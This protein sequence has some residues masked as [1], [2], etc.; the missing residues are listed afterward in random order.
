MLKILFVGQTW[1]GSCARSMKEALAKHPRIDLDEM[2][3]D[4]FT[5]KVNSKLLRGLNK[6]VR[7]LYRKEFNQQV[8]EK[9]RHDRP[10]FFVT[11]KGSFVQS[12]L[13][14]SVADLGIQTVNIYPDCSP[15]AHGKA[16]R[17]AVGQYNIVI[18]TKEYH[19]ALWSDLYHYANRCRFVPQGYDPLLHYRDAPP[20]SFEYDVVMIATI[21]ST[22]SR[23]SRLVK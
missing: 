14:Q 2:A 23:V 4:A 17:K 1:P 5:P 22:D 21:W 6:V 3:E 11:Y 8:M 19:P 15:H 12:D 13:L 16:H 18:S 7:P 9:I 20:T 10:D